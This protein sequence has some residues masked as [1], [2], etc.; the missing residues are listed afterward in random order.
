MDFILI[1]TLQNC[2][3]EAEEE[4]PFYAN[5]CLRILDRVLMEIRDTMMV[6]IRIIIVDD[7]VD[8]PNFC[9]EAGNLMLEIN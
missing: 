6:D 7:R 3:A 2:L 9:H 4:L 8:E 1:K 5:F